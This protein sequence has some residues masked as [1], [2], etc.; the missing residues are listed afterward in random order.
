MQVRQMNGVFKMRSDK[1]EIFTSILHRDE[2]LSDQRSEH[3]DSRPIPY[4]VD[5]D[6]SAS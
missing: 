4:Q 3:K 6:S 2:I 1:E 5:P